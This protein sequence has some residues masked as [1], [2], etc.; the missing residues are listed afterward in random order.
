MCTLTEKRKVCSLRNTGRLIC[1]KKY[2]YWYYGVL[3]FSWLSWDQLKLIVNQ[4][5]TRYKSALTYKTNVKICRRLSLQRF[6]LFNEKLVLSNAKRNKLQLLTNGWE[7]KYFFQLE[8]K[9]FS[10]NILNTLIIY[11]H[12]S[13][14]I[15]LDQLQ[16]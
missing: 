8:Q 6:I 16:K 15:F 3:A 11:T 2:S 5:R 4:S 10:R 14:W 13:F 9:L 12:Q 1:K 7:I